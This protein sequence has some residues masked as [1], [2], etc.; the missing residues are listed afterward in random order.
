MGVSCVYC[1]LFFFVTHTLSAASSEIPGSGGFVLHHVFTAQKVA[2][3]PSS[4]VLVSIEQISLFVCK[5][6]GE[7]NTPNDLNEKGKKRG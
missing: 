1:Y 6:S 3:A 4:L 5:P 2:N 7:E